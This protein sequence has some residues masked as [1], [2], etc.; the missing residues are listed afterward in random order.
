MKTRQP[1]NQQLQ[2]D[3]MAYCNRGNAYQAKSGKGITNVV[4]KGRKKYQAIQ[5]DMILDKAIILPWW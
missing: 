4:E 1:Q 2:Y 3:A 5:L